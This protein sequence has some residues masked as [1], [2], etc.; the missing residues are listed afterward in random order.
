MACLC[1]CSADYVI[2]EIEDSAPPQLESSRRQQQQ[3]S[4]RCRVE[5]GSYLKQRFKIEASV[6][7]PT[8]CSHPFK[9]HEHLKA[10]SLLRGPLAGQ[11][12]TTLNIKTM[13]KIRLSGNYY[14][15]SDKHPPTQKW[16]FGRETLRPIVT[17]PESQIDLSL[18]LFFKKIS[19]KR[20]G[21]LTV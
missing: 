15:A 9:A 10:A 5:K 11:V 13:R 16:L 14:L 12:C 20:C 8:S 21:V 1:P 17:K 2:A 7:K 6:P 4:D 19:F 3:A 18:I